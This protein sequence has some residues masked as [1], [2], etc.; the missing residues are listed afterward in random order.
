[1][2][3]ARGKTACYNQSIENAGVVFVKGA[4]ERIDFFEKK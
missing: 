2:V 4:N 3:E 1:M